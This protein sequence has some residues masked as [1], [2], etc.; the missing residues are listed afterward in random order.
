MAGVWSDTLVGARVTVELGFLGRGVLAVGEGALEDVSGVNALV[1]HE[2]RDVL[3]GEAAGV[4][5]VGLLLAVR[6]PVLLQRAAHGVGAP[7]RLALVLELAGVAPHVHQ[8]VR[9]RS[10]LVI[11]DGAVMRLVVASLLPMSQEVYHFIARVVACN[12]ETTRS[13]TC[14]IFRRK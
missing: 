7:A 9:T 14:H 5:Q 13:N 4:A 2:V 6:R 11:T 3:G 1:R 12:N 8:E 10:A